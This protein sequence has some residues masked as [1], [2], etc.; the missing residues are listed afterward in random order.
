MG[1]DD[2]RLPQDLETKLQEYNA[3]LAAIKSEWVVDEID[4]DQNALEE[5][6][7]LAKNALA[8]AAP[9]AVETLFQL[10]SYSESDS[11]RQRS[12]MYILDKVLGESGS[13]DPSDPMQ[14]LLKQLAAASPD[15]T[16]NAPTLE[17]TEG[18]ED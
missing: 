18:R 7:Q 1:R 16:P 2:D 14:R 9:K 13:A 4:D 12:S 17:L 8:D 15:P 3:K 5:K 11:V 6:A 10:M